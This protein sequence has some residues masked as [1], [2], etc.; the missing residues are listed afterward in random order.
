MAEEKFMDF[1][2]PNARVLVVDDN[3]MS[4]KLAV[5][6]FASFK[7]QADCAESGAAAL[8]KVK[9]QS[10]HLI[11]MDY[12]MPEMDGIETTLRIREMADDHYKTIP[13]I[14]L[15]GDEA[16]DRGLL[17]EVGICDFLL[18]PLERNFLKAVLGKWLPSGLLAYDDGEKVQESVDA[19]A[20]WPDLQGI[21]I[22][23]GL[24][25]SGSREHLYDF[26]CDFYHLIDVKAE[27]L[28][29]CMAD[30]QIKEYTIEVHALKNSARIIGAGKLSGLFNMLEQF[31]KAE[32]E[33]AIHRE[34]ARV[35]AEYRS[36]KEILAP[37]CAKSDEAKRTVSTEEMLYYLQ[38]L[39]EA[40]EAFDMDRA[41]E[42]M[43]Q[44]EEMCFPK[45]CELLMNK[46]RAAVADV[47]MENILIMSEEIISFLKYR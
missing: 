2:A 15:T 24:K 39:Q 16:A 30:R 10:Y 32:D 8:E 18:K 43:K 12:L 47:A 41:D 25:N 7:I 33:D 1:I 9:K 3:R 22:K 5:N 19:K 44:L 29:K 28:E 40:T 17:A 36:F 35:L 31:G 38:G 21:D 20:E 26:F 11:F 37:L 34:H 23:E 6:L 13:I 45:E 4:L 46:L 42:A 27:K 14:A